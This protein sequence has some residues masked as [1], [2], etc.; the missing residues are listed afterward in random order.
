MERKTNEKRNWLMKNWLD[1]NRKENL[2]SKSEKSNGKVIF[3][4]I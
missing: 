3:L 2:Q 1:F 4:W